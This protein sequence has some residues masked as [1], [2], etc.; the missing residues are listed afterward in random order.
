MDY[1]TILRGAQ[2]VER[3]ATKLWEQLSPREQQ[4][5]Y[6]VSFSSAIGDSS[7]LVASL[8]EE[9]QVVPDHFD[10]AE[11]AFATYFDLTQTIK[12]RDRRLKELL[13]VRNYASRLTTEI[14]D[15]LN[16]G[17]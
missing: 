6:G 10:L 17:E 8:E 14:F 9:E 1:A 4:H 2:E 15:F 5:P 11:A 13:R 7:N 3:R 12:R 16:P